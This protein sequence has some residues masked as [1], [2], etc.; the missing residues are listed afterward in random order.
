MTRNSCENLLALDFENGSVL[1]CISS[2][3]RFGGQPE[4]AQSAVDEVPAKC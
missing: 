2:A 1:Y 3:R 4:L